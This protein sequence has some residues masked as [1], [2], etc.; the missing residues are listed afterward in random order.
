VTRLRTGVALIGAS[1]SL[2][3]AGC[4]GNAEPAAKAAP[5][6]RCSGAKLASWQRLASRVDALVYCPTWM[7]DPL[8]GVIGSRWNNIDSV[9]PDRS[10]LQSWVWQETGPGVAGG[11]LHVNLRG[12]PGRT[13]VPRC[14]D[15][16]TNAKVPCFSDPHGQ[17]RF[18]PIT[19]T[20][21]TSNR[22][23][24]QWHVAYGWRADGG[25]YTLSEHVAPPLT[26]SKVVRYLNRMMAS[27][28]PVEPSA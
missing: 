28:Q 10:Y 5:E 24:D 23:A 15:A 2:A 12:Y 25:F 14:R 11:E 16:D 21:Y 1:L 3:L 22:D 13:K 19:A 18:G 26:Y 7:P 8:D 27:L 20:L 6:P 4:G 17:K 9:D